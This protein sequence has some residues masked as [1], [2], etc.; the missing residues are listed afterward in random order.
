MISYLKVLEW[1]VSW[2]KSSFVQL[3]WDNQISSILKLSV[4]THV[5]LLINFPEQFELYFCFEY[6]RSSKVL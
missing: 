6:S 4:Y 2:E 1:Y 5:V 3:P